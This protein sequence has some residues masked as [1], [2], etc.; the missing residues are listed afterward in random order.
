MFERI[1][2]GGVEDRNL[3]QKLEE[4]ASMADDGNFGNL[5]SLRLSTNFHD[6]I[7][8]FERPPQLHSFM[9]T[10]KNPEELGFDGGE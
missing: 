4:F 2:I 7:A 8:S 10:A 1:I 5:L 6:E 9:A 3:K